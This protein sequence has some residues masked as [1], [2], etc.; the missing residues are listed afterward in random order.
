M[1]S[2]P[3]EEHPRPVADGSFARTI[4]APYGA[5]HSARHQALRR[6]R[7]HA[8]SRRTRRSRQ[9]ES[10]QIVD[11]MPLPLPFR[12]DGLIANIEEAR[13][14]RIHLIPIPDRL[15]SA[16]GVCGLWIKHQT[17]PLDLILH[18]KSASRF[19]ERQIILHELVH[20][21]ADDAD[22]V[23]GDHLDEL[24][25]GLSGP[26]VDRLI[27]EGQI[28]ARR[29][30]DTDRERRTEAAAALIHERAYASESIAD[31]TARQ[32]AADLLYPFG[33][34][35]YQRTTDHV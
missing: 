27:S 10:H 22:G 31:P 16:S 9:I 6:I 34:P 28:S 2:M 3:S 33:G 25:S 30:Y 21:W 13:G 5:L 29:R 4:L 23:T 20:L 18:V 12:L 14:R 17:E 26:L 32:L 19:H 24:M 7:D 11:S 35:D 1:T 8:K 15:L